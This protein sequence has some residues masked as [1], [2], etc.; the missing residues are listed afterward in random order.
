MFPGHPHR[1]AFSLVVL[2]PWKI[3]HPPRES[4]SLQVSIEMSPS[5]WGLVWLHIRTPSGASLLTHRFSPQHLSLSNRAHMFYCLSPYILLCKPHM[6]RTLLP[7]RLS[8]TRKVPGTQQM[9]NKYWL[10]QWLLT[11]DERKDTKKSRKDN[12][13][14]ITQENFIRKQKSPKL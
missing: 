10:R 12:V 1:R 5:H 4:P 6:E 9:V 14:S 11:V 7:A 2:H 13:I 8:A 3:I